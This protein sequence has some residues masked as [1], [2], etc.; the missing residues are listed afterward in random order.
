MFHRLGITLVALALFT[1]AGGHW[2]VLQSVAWGQMLNDYSRGGSFTTAV[3][4]TFSGKYPCAMCRKIAEAKK[5]E[6]Q[7]A[8]LLKADK[9]VEVFVAQAAALLRRPVAEEFSHPAVADSRFASRFD[10]PPVPVPI[11]A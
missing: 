10:Q 5:Q 1:I 8:P 11:V 4:K 9:K 2:L 7:K 6:E 3:E